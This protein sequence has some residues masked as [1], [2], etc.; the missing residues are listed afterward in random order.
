M[1]VEGKRNAPE[2]TAQENFEDDEIADHMM[3]MITAFL[4]TRGIEGSFEAL[5]DDV[6][7]WRHLAIA[8]ALES[9]ELKKPDAMN[10]VLWHKLNGKFYNIANPADF[11]LILGP[12]KLVI[13]MWIADIASTFG[14]E[15][16]DTS[17]VNRL[18]T[19]QKL[20]AASR[21]AW[22]L[23]E[24]QRLGNA[25][26]AAKILAKECGQSQEW[27][28]QRVSHLKSGYGPERKSTS[29]ITL[30]GLDRFTRTSDEVIKVAEEAE[31]QYEGNRVDFIAA[32]VHKII[33]DAIQL[34]VE[35]H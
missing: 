33:D 9:G 27:L 14:M 7:M 21:D 20:R 10:S 34:I 30:R 26:A 8:L 2:T 11:E 3:E 17:W 31:L 5:V 4:R 19:W 23:F 28:R 6:D 22:L 18:T 13:A 35:N 1:A 24:T 16:A 25:N 29:I 12:P 15:Y 32:A